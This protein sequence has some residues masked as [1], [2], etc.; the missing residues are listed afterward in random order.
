MAQHCFARLTPEVWPHTQDW[1]R[2]NIEEWTRT[3]VVYVMAGVAHSLYDDP[4]FSWDVVTEE[5]P[6][7]RDLLPY[8]YTKAPVKAAPYR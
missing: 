1:T 4:F 3:Q 8:I 7:T 2:E 6:Q 5:S